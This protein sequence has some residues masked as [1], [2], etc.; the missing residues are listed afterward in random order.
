MKKFF[1]DTNI[2]LSW[3]ISSRD[4][5]SE[6]T[7]FMKEIFMGRVEGFVSSHSLSDIFYIARKNYSVEERKNFLLLIASNFQIVP[8]NQNDFFEVLSSP[9]FFDIED[10][11]QMRCAEKVVVDYI[12][13]ENLKDFL[14]S[15]V[16]AVD[17]ASALKIILN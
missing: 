15:K 16:P 17:T 8:E 1:V 13:T 3:L 9:T 14:S 4:T 5:H 7:S 10:G 11:L 6:A 2:I 12:V